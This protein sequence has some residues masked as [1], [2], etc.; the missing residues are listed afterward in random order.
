MADYYKDTLTQIISRRLQKKQ[1]QRSLVNWP[2]Q[3]ALR[4][5]P[6]TRGTYRQKTNTS[7]LKMTRLP[8]QQFPT[9]GKQGI[10]TSVKT[11]KM[12]KFSFL[13]GL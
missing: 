7:N 12:H 8:N 3:N 4:T 5:R 6:P 9:I 1:S 10:Q 13:Q 11:P 2:P